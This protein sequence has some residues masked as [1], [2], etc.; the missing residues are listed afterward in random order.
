MRQVGDVVDLARN[1]VGVGEGK[2][3]PTG[4][5]GRGGRAL[6]AQRTEFSKGMSGLGRD[7]AMVSCH[8]VSARIAM[9]LNSVWPRCVASL[10]PG[11]LAA[12][13]A[14]VLYRV[15]GARPRHPKKDVE[16]ALVQLEE[17]G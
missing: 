6:A 11:A 5:Q 9:V 2:V 4:E 1:R 10:P 16:N 14:K 3:A 13:S 17:A 8:T 15:N 12:L 7:N